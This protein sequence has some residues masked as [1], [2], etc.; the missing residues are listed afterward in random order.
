MQGDNRS[1]I[2]WHTILV[3]LGINLLIGVFLY[4]HTFVVQGNILKQAEA[5][6]MHEQLVNMESAVQE[7]KDECQL[8][9]T[10]IALDPDVKKAF[11]KNDRDRLNKLILPVY[12]QW[13]DQYWVNQLQF[14]STRGIGVWDMNKPISS[15][16]DDLSYRRVIMQSIMQKQRL[17]VIES[18]EEV[19]SI[20]STVPLFDGD[21]FIGLCEL[22]ISLD[23]SLG[24]R[25]KNLTSGNYTIFELK[26]IESRVL[27]QKRATRMVLNTDDIR[28]TQEGKSFYRPSQDKKVM[29]AVVPLKD[30]DCITVAYVQGEIPRRTF[31][32]ALYYN[33]LFMGLMMA[34][35]LFASVFT[36]KRTGSYSSLDLL[37]QWTDKGKISQLNIRADQTINSRNEEQ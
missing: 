22:G 35:M 27:W 11:I 4:W 33:Y 23:K 29:L 21:K 16:D 6:Y 8:L 13:Q 34:F 37:D 14:I 26:G 10:R 19:Q 15:G 36:A 30:V 17:A 12:S 20:V 18:T 2:Q 31:T 32:K 5:A 28:K 24:D 9:T 3:L 7:I 1:R 25:L